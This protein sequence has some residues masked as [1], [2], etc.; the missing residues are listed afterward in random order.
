MSQQPTIFL[1]STFADNL[2]AQLMARRPAKLESGIRGDVRA[3]VSVGA[4]CEVNFNFVEGAWSLKPPSGFGEA[5]A[6]RRL[7]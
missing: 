1:V 3:L 5:M 4:G 6:E 2:P 7:M